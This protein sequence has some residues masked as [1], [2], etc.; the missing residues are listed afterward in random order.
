[1]THRSPPFAETPGVGRL[2]PASPFGP[3][4]ERVGDTGERGR[5][6]AAL[7][8]FS[9]APTVSFVFALTRF[10]FRPVNRSHLVTM[11]SA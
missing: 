4:S 6:R 10:A 9:Y 8:A 11:T 3:R 7:G 5:R 2:S 1:M